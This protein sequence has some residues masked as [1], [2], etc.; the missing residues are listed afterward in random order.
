MLKPKDAT[1]DRGRENCTDHLLIQIQVEGTYR[2]E[3]VVLKA[4]IKVPLTPKIV[5]R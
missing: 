1:T 5:F 3:K 4:I 2:G